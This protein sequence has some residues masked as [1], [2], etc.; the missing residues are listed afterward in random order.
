[1]RHLA[2][3]L[4]Q[5]HVVGAL[6]VCGAALGRV[7][8]APATDES[9]VRLR[10]MPAG[11][12]VGGVVVDVGP[13]EI[14]NRRDFIYALDFDDSS[15]RLAFTQHVSTDMELTLASLSPLTPVFQEK[16]NPSEYDL[17]DVVVVGDRVYVP[18][19][20]GTLRAFSAA[21][22]RRLAEA[23]TGEPMIRIAVDAEH[24]Y[25]GSGDGRVLI[26]DRELAFVGETKLHDDEIR[27]LAVAADGRLL[28][29]SLDGTFK[30]AKVVA[31]DD[32]MVRLPISALAS[33]EQV[34]L[35]HL[36]GRQAVPTIRDARQSHT[37]ISRA[38]VK[39]LQLT[40]TT[41]T[42][43]GV[44]TAEGEQQLPALSIGELRLRGLSL[45]DVTAAVCDS[46][47]PPGAE[48]A[49]GQDVLNTLSVAE[50]IAGG[51]LVVRPAVGIEAVAMV[52]GARQ[53]VI[54]QTVALPGP[55]ND[56][57]VSPALAGTALVTFSN[58][59][60]ER[61]YEINEGERK[62]AVLPTSPKSGAA[63]IDLQ[64]ATITKQFVSQH[65]GFA[66]TG[67]LAVDGK[68]IATG[69]WDKRV[70]VFDVAS[71]AVVFERAFGWLV[72]RV[73]FSPDGRLL[74]V[75]AWT[76]VNALNEGDSDPSLILYPLR[77]ATP[78]F[79]AGSRP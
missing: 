29:A 76:P 46:C 25:A 41:S 36:A 20:Q 4:L 31:V 66:V 28:S 67:A 58:T 51:D 3:R 47:L 60:A 48:L 15:A 30:I 38:A 44:V 52:A 70:I 78:T 8:T 10:A 69:G 65:H 79:V 6:A 2:A 73:R 12:Y 61:S 7:T 16:V 9:L 71:G 32:A 22:G 21:D 1:M 50:D 54:E 18:S 72:R 33:G 5:R 59:R 17:E 40:S 74:A 68:T 42:T 24:V 27:G 56:L 49:L 13:P 63:L 11:S 26:F 62:G 53:L 64:T 45:G 34:F 19:R 37:V 39:R 14:V 43:V 23:T 77:Y 35:A 57:D 75:A 55:A